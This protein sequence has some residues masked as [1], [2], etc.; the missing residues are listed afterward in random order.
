MHC[1]VDKIQGLVTVM[2]NYVVSKLYMVIASITLCWVYLL[3]VIL[4]IYLVQFFYIFVQ[5][6]F[7]GFLPYY[8]EALWDSICF[9]FSYMK[10]MQKVTTNICYSHDSRKEMQE[11]HCRSSTC[12]LLFSVW[13]ISWCIVG[14]F[15]TLIE[16][17]KMGGRG[18]LSLPR[19]WHVSESYMN[20]LINSSKRTV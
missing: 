2:Q 18:R 6:H 13:W 5:L 19:D 14:S 1:C 15:F 9:V 8:A 4:L 16:I 20:R 10:V 17:V 11:S 12:C 3:I 7:L